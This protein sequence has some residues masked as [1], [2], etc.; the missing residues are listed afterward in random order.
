MGDVGVCVSYGNYGL[1]VLLA[2]V[3]YFS[4]LFLTPLEEKLKREGDV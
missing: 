3:I 2:A 1:A 4:L